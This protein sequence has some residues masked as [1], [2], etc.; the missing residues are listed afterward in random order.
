MEYWNVE[1]PGFVGAGILG[2]KAEINYLN[3]CKI[4]INFHAKLRQ[5]IVGMNAAVGVLY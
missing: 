1:N 4:L 3:C 5:F 2:I